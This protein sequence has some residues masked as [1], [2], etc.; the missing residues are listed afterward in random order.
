VRASDLSAAIHFDIGEAYSAD[1]LRLLCQCMSLRLDGSLLRPPSGS[2]SPLKKENLREAARESDQ[3]FA[4]P[5][6]G[7]YGRMHERHFTSGP[8]VAVAVS[9]IAARCSN[10][11]ITGHPRLNSVAEPDRFS[12][13]AGGCS[14]LADIPRR[15]RD[16]VP[17]FPASFLYP[18][19]ST[20]LA[21]G[22]T[23]WQS[24]YPRPICFA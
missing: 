14:G 23:L 24:I 13:N 4:C 7:G 8:A 9:Y 16:G 10:G 6:Q 1:A 12:Y 22:R 19:E 21:I 2:E 5:Y 11:W 3:T 17:Q 18:H 15:E 20:T